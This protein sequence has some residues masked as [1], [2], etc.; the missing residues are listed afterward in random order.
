LPI[1]D[2]TP[3]VVV[4]KQSEESWDWVAGGVSEQGLPHGNAGACSTWRKT[5]ISDDCEKQKRNILVNGE[6]EIPCQNRHSNIWK[7]GID[8]KNS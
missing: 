1:L 8:P 3:V 7:G 5:Y 6:K 4:L 2:S